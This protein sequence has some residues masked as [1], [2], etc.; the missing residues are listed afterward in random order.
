MIKTQ[1][2]INE[3]ASA[4]QK[5][6]AVL[7]AVE[8]R[9]FSHV[10]DGATSDDIARA[11]GTDPRCTDR[12]LNAM[13]SLGLME[14]KGDIFLNGPGAARF[15]V[16]SGDDYMSGLLHSANCYRNWG[17]LDKAVRAGTS[18]INLEWDS[19]DRREAFIE[20]MHRRAKDTS[21]DLVRHLD[22]TNVRRV[23]DVGGGSG[24]YSMAMCRAK[25]GLTSVVLDLPEV[26]ELA[27]RYVFAEDLGD[28]ITTRDGSYHEA[29]YGSG[30]DL[31][32]FSAIIHI[33]SPEENRNLIGKAFSALNPG[34]RIV[35]QDFIM[36]EDRLTPPG[37]T[38][39]ALNMVVSTRAGDT[40]TESEITGWMNDA[41]C[42]DMQLI[43]TG[44]ATAMVS[45]QKPDA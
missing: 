37:G 8:L 14:K 18:A 16:E 4:W 24:V 5:S 42:V 43:K 9:I 20:A 19:S 22:L 15:L 28:R 17:T 10:G 33:N 26:T 23:L 44:P 39:F 13:V 25:D 1:Q 30:Y 45:G 2:E 7:A 29:D 38:L 6:R 32:F 12:L 31:V 41:G 40:Y 34:G 3:L 27:R 36:G 35:V 11:A 21:A